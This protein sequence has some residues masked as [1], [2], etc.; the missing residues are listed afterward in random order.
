MTFSP[1]TLW[2]AFPGMLGGYERISDLALSLGFDAIAPR[3]G[4][5]L[6]NGNFAPSL[7][8]SDLTVMKK[9][10]MLVYPWIFSRPAS[11]NA[12]VQAFGQ[13]EDAGADACIIDAEVPWDVDPNAKDHAHRYGELM[14]R[15]VMVPVYDAPWPAIAFHPGYPEE[16]FRWVAGRLVQAYWTEIGWSARKTL[17]VMHAQWSGKD[18]RLLPIGI[19]YGKKEIAKWGQKQTPPG[20]IDPAVCAAVAPE[21]TGGWYSMEA[22]GTGVLEA[23]AATFTTVEVLPTQPDTALPLG[24]QDRAEQQQDECLTFYCRNRDVFNYGTS[25]TDPAPATSTDSATTLPGTPSS[26]SSQR[27]KAVRPEE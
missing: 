6:G 16:A 17:D 1:R 27:L 22:A 12:E 15:E 2:V 25:D 4:E 13:Y 3:A 20:E 23:V 5:G 24:W 18:D 11:V 8:P 7:R 10:G 21:C 19:T 26:K 9:R 14:G